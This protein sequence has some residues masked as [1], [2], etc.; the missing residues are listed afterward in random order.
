LQYAGGGGAVC[1][2]PVA[3]NSLEEEAEGPAVQ[4]EDKM[5]PALDGIS[6][7]RAEEVKMDDRMD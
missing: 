4:W 7:E 1:G 5:E 6:G 2:K 3:R